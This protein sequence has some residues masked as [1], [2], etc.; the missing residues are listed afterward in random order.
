M[1]Y[2]VY[3]RMGSSPLVSLAKQIGELRNAVRKEHKD[4]FTNNKVVSSCY[5]F[6]DKLPVAKPGPNQQV[7][8]VEWEGEDFLDSSTQAKKRKRAAR[9]EEEDPDYRGSAGASKNRSTTA[10]ATKTRRIANETPK[11]APTRPAQPSPPPAVR[12]SLSGMD[13]AHPQSRPAQGAQMYS[14]PYTHTQPDPRS[15]NVSP[16]ST[17]RIED[18]ADTNLSDLTGS[19]DHR[20][21]SSR[22][23]STLPPCS[24]TLRDLS[25]TL[26]GLSMA[27]STHKGDNSAALHRSWMRRSTCV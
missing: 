10:V 19:M 13:A 8:A 20:L 22:L 23:L 25:N 15:Y 9:E 2:I 17:D 5:H 4:V 6:V 21:L 7:A 16:D 18:P 3:C 1:G 24:T 11:A 14:N 27:T 12:P 26:N